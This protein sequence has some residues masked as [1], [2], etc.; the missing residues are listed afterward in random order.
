MIGKSTVEM[1]YIGFR[2]FFRNSYFAS[3][4]QI[5]S[6]LACGTFAAELIAVEAVAM[7]IS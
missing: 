7:A 2:R 6:M 3:W 5:V 4:K 1:E